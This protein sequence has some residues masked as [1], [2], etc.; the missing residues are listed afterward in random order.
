WVFRRN[1]PRGI[2]HPGRVGDGVYAAANRPTPRD[3]LAV[4]QYQLNNPAIFS[5]H[6]LAA[7]SIQHHKANN[8][9]HT[10]FEDPTLNTCHCWGKTVLVWWIG[11]GRQSFNIEKEGSYRFIIRCRRREF[12]CRRSRWC[13]GGGGGGVLGSDQN[14]KSAGWLVRC[15]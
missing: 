11:V 2:P 4:R 10:A 3:L 6:A 5:R 13:G 9:L 7:L 1:T 12:L 14:G 8:H 15:I